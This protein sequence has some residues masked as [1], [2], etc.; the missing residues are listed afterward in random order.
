MA[1]VTNTPQPFQPGF[2]L[3][4][5]ALL[6]A[7]ITRLLQSTDS[8][9]T[10]S[11]TQTRAGAKPLTQIINQ[12]SSVANANDSVKLPPSGTDAQGNPYPNIIFVLNDGGNNA[13]VFPGGANDQIDSSGAATAVVITNA[14]RALFWCYSD[15]GGIRLWDSLATTKTT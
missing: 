15:V 1:E 9:I 7:I 10:A 13:Q 6:N 8:G 3:I 4:D 11:T 2:R 5:G 14:K 12:L